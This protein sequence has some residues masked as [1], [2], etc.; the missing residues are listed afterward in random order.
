[1]TERFTQTTDFTCGPACLV[2]VLHY[3]FPEREFTTADE[4]NI[5]REANTVFMGEGSPGTSAY[6]LALAAEKRGLATTVYDFDHAH[7]F[8]I[9]QGERPDFEQDVLLRMLKHDEAEYRR[10]SRGDIFYRRATPEDWGNQFS[11]GRLA[12]VLIK[13][14]T[15]VDL[16]WVLVHKIENGYVHLHDPYPYEN[17]ALR[18]IVKQPMAFHTFWQRTNLPPFSSHTVVFVDKR[19]EG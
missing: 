15:D 19:E 18:A 14:F 5:W 7:L 2:S 1:M 9:N 17:E 4:F 16:H 11:K 6:G 8:A 10:E 3:F 12:I 13:D